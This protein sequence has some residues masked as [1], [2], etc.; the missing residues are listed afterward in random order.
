M[1]IRRR[2]ISVFA[3]AAILGAGLLH[4]SQNVQQAEDA[5]ASHQ[6]SYNAQREA[7]QVLNAEWAYLNSPARIE[8]LTQE[9][10]DLQAPHSDQMMPDMPALPPAI[11]DIPTGGETLFHNISQTPEHDGAGEVDASEGVIV[12][13]PPMRKPKSAKGN[14]ADLLKR[15]GKGGSQ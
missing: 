15:A 11:I 2:T 10:L 5:L 9:Y 13:P 1:K 4:V 14:F 12:V 3:V 6:R 8:A 7:I